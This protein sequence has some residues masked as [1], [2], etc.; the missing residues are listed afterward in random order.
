[1]SYF[2]N[3][4]SAALASEFNDSMVQY[5]GLI[6][7][8]ETDDVEWVA[9]ASSLAILYRSFGISAIQIQDMYH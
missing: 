1:M 2:W 3:A 4:I 6:E 7:D 9:L 8:G 5:G